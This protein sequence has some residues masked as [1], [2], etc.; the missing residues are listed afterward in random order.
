MEKVQFFLLPVVKRIVF[1]LAPLWLLL[2]VVYE[3]I[4]ELDMGNSWYSL[5]FYISLISLT[6]FGG[7][8]YKMMEEP[9]LDF[10][11]I[12]TN[13]SPRWKTIS[14]T[15]QTFVFRPRF[16][17]PYNLMSGETVR[18]DCLDGKAKV[19]G[20]AYYV[21]S[22]V[23][24]YK[25]KRNPIRNKFA[26]VAIPAMVIVL[27]LVPM[28][29]GTGVIAD[30]KIMYHNHQAR[31]VDRIVIADA[32]ASG[33]TENNSINDGFAATYADRIFLVR[34]NVDLVSLSDDFQEQNYLID[35]T[36]GSG[37]SRLNIVGSWIFYTEGKNLNR[38]RLDGTEKETIY[39][40]GYLLD[41][42][43]IG[44]D[45]YFISFMDRFAVHRM[46][47]NGQNLERFIDKDVIDIA[48]IE[49]RLFYS[50]E[51]DGTGALE[52]VDLNGKNRKLELEKPIQ[53]LVYAGDT[54][55]FL[56]FDDNKLY[57][58]SGEAGTAPKI[59]V[60]EPVSSYIA[61]EEGIYY[62]LFSKDGAYPGSGLYKLASDSSKLVL[63]DD[64]NSIENLS[65]TNEWLLITGYDSKHYL[66]EQR[67]NLLT[68]EISMMP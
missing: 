16:D 49:G 45:I 24:D 14:K 27:L 3:L 50:Y 7:Y 62:S 63:L 19:E 61:T 11:M 56:G 66:F 4:F 29:Y 34:D 26:L 58:Y 52:S 15:D 43:V 17:F 68:D 42:H 67:L 53:D 35:K 37:I 32:T 21:N 2:F 46:D 41:V 54:F 48:I 25:G 44:N 20:P 59:L 10:E 65:Q 39:K 47:V 60:D 31:D 6:N 40:A 8:R 30:W 1:F 28:L 33:N 23:R 22:W 13:S 64:V 36:S 9:L 12:E 57:S 51:E 5:T 55:Y 18:V 38:M